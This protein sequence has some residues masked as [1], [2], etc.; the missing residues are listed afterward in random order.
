M[1]KMN[2]FLVLAWVA[3]IA[4]VSTSVS[5]SLRGRDL[6]APDAAE[7][8][9]GE[10]S[11][12]EM[13]DMG[14]DEQQEDRD[15]ARRGRGGY[16]GYNTGYNGYGNGGYSSNAAYGGYGSGYGSTSGY[17]SGYGGYGRGS[18]GYGSGYGSSGYGTSGY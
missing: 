14:L 17:G 13:E 18:S 9:E 15:L 16:G 1:M 5:A 8:F 10:L 7:H 12:E 6:E 2:L 3:L 4:T 11:L